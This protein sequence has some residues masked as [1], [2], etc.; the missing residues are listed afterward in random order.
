MSDTNY[1][2]IPLSHA[3]L[4]NQT[5]DAVNARDL[6][7]F[8]ESKRQFSNWI[9]YQIEAFGFAQDVDFVT[10]NNSEFSPPRK[11]YYISMDMAKELS[12]VERNAKGKQARQYF[13]E[14]EK[15]LHGREVEQPK[16][17]STL[18]LFDLQLKITKEHDFRLTHMEEKV[19]ALTATTE[20]KIAAIETKLNTPMELKV[21]PHLD[22]YLPI[23]TTGRF[24]TVR[25]FVSLYYRR[26]QF[27]PFRFS[28]WSRSIRV[29]CEKRSIRFYGSRTPKGT[30]IDLEFPVWVLIEVFKE[31][32][33]NYVEEAYWGRPVTDLK[34]AA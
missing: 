12:M 13:V 22:G 30:W 3:I 19:V 29:R 32:F 2:L 7:S 34:K 16:A 21:V 14:C 25:A 11:E 28:A 33:P 4:D 1:T 31:W 27:S 17:M 8:L 9:T 10:I 26:A 24:L 15:K 20:E 23:D 5:V 18:E 6:H